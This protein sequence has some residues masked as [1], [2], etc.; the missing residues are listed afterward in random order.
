MLVVEGAQEAAE[1]EITLEEAVKLASRYREEG[2]SL[3]DAAKKRH[4]R[5]ALKRENYTDCWPDDVFR[6]KG[7]KR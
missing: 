4:L 5:R 2:L 3:S 6:K 1:K 7:R